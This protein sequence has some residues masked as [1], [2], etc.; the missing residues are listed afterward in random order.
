[1]AKKSASG[2]HHTTLSGC[3]IAI[4]AHVDNRK[5]LVKQQYLPHMSLQYGELRPTN[6]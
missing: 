5:N 6:G 3:I 1:M 4:K 2:H